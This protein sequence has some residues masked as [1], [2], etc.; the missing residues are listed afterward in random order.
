LT[1]SASI[2]L[3][4][5]LEIGDELGILSVFAERKPMRNLLAIV[6]V[7]GAL[8]SAH[9]ATTEGDFT[10]TLKMRESRKVGI[11]ASLGGQ[12]GLMG[13]NTEINFEDTNSA[14]AGIGKGPGY[15]SVQLAWKHAF[16]G[17]YIAPYTTVGYSRW[18]NS[19]GG[20]D[21]S[22]SAILRRVLTAS[23]K[24]S[25]TFG[26]DFLNASVGLQYN[27]LSG[28]LAGLS[29]YAEFMLMTEVKRGEILPNGVVGTTFFF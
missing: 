5:E 4:V 27:Q 25:G 11:G 16:D 15:N 17:D 26:T 20:H 28:E 7:F 19:S 14:I 6:F 21:Y 13:I 10:S 22:D 29:V 1:L 12:L 18:F 2:L 9:A 24:A 8:S 3:E 23:E